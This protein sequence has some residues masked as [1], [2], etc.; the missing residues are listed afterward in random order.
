[1]QAQQ[2]ASPLVKRFESSGMEFIFDSHTSKIFRLTEEEASAFDMWVAGAR[3]SEVARRYPSEGRMIQKSAE[4]GL[5]SSQ[6]SDKMS[7]GGGLSAVALDV[8]SKRTLTILEIT[9][10]CNLR[11]GY[12]TF[13]D[14]F[15]DH[16]KL[17]GQTMSITVLRAAI[18]DA[19]QCASGLERLSIGFYGGEPLAAF[20]MIQSAVQYARQQA[21][22][23]EIRFSLTT[24]ATLLDRTKA[25]YLRD[26]EFSVLVSVDGPRV[27]HDRYRVY[28]DGKGSYDDTM[29]GLKFLLEA[30]DLPLRDK[31][32]LN[33]VL[34]TQQWGDHL[35][36]LWIE[37]PWLP[38][39]LR[40]QAG[41]VD[42][43]DGMTPPPP[44]PPAIADKTVKGAWMLS[45]ENNNSDCPPLS[46]E[47]YDSELARIH[48]R[49]IHNGP[50]DSFYPNGCCVPGAR[51]VYVR[52]DGT[53]QVCERA[54]GVPTI[55]SVNNGVDVD[56]VLK[57]T[58]EYVDRS[59]DDCKDCWAIPLCSLCFHH[60]YECA[61]FNTKRK[62]DMCKGEQDRLLHLL[63]LYAWVLE[64]HPE[65]LHLWERIQ[66]T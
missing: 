49:E 3:L 12:C 23:K 60:G 15:S 65:R 8:R 40:A 46:S 51:R 1:M 2:K 37:N 50:R 19:V 20:Q 32:G 44:P 48:Q 63:K 42:A 57:L 38:N 4:Q 47:S 58:R 55:G 61:G 7:F 39:G 17:N 36:K 25:K 35:W 13:G 26:N 41:L 56:R 62:R 43:P 14:G 9:Q 16:R 18:D 52:V 27:M 64:M 22:N 45:V 24:N 28:Q 30:Y 10:R 33:M 6:R 21:G 31:I 59:K 5:F 66:I 29:Q 11:C 53:Y 54:H 34:P